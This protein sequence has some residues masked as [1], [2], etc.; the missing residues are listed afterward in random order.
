[1]KQVSRPL[2]PALMAPRQPEHVPKVLAIVS[3]LS[4]RKLLAE[5]LTPRVALKSRSPIAQAIPFMASENIGI[6]GPVIGAPAAVLALEPFL[7]AGV[8]RALLL[9]VCGGIALGKTQL[10][11]GDF[12]FP[13]KLVTD[14][15]TSVLYGAARSFALNPSAFQLTLEKKIRTA[16]GKLRNARGSPPNTFETT[17]CTTDA[18]YR[19]TLEK[20]ESCFRLGA[21]GIEMEL[22]AVAHLARIYDAE[23][24]AALVVSDLFSPQWTPGLRSRPVKAS[25]AL[26]VKAAAEV[27]KGA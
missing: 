15:G 20:I 2:T 24:A 7:A 14:D 6:I 11:L 26:A 12:L 18:P 22:A 8:K 9:G 13:R 27:M 1:M 23:L 19:E 21:L 4:V 25:V 10:A 3:A 16:C 17:I 5:C